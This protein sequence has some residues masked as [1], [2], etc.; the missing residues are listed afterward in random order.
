ME[1]RLKELCLTRCLYVCLF[2]SVSTISHKF[3]DQISWNLEMDVLWMYYLEKSRILNLG[4]RDISV[5]Q[6]SRISVNRKTMLTRNV[7]QCPT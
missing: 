1:P 5:N 4:I 2:R 7:G 6:L 3:G